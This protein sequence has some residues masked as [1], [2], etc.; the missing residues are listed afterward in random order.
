VYD[1]DGRF[2]KNPLGSYTINNLTA[3]RDADG[4]VTVQFGGCNNTIPNCIPTHPG[5]NYMVRLY[6]PRPEILDGTFTFPQGKPG[7]R[8]RLS[9][10]RPPGPD[11]TTTD[12]IGFHQGGP[13][14]RT[15]MP[16]S[17]HCHAELR[18]LLSSNNSLQTPLVCWHS[19]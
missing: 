14:E 8:T 17:A 1:A 19:E 5:W 9:F 2:R 10:E 15:L 13:R 16:P 6:R 12:H 18:T 3:Q 4:S 11:W 7:H